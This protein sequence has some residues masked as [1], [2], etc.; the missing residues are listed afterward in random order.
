MHIVRRRVV[1]TLLINLCISQ[2]CKN[3]VTDQMACC[4]GNKNNVVAVMKQVPVVKISNRFA[5][6]RHAV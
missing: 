2:I 4:V 5:R 1:L 6:G 3:I